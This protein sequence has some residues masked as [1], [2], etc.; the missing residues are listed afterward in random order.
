MCASNNRRLQFPDIGVS[1]ELQAIFLDISSR[2]NSFQTVQADIDDNKKRWLV[3]GICL[4][5]IVS[6]SL[7]KYVA[8]MMKKL[9]VELKMSKKIHKQS[10]SNYLKKYPVTN[11]FYLNYE[12][13]NNNHQQGQN[14]C[15]Y[16]YQVKNF[17]DL[18]KLFLQARMACYT[19]FDDTCD[20]SA[21]LGIIIRVDIFPQLIRNNAKYVRTDVRNPW[22]HCDFSVWD[23]IR[24][25]SSLQLMEQ[26]IRSLNLPSTDEDIVLGDLLKWKMNGL[27]FFSD[28]TIGLEL[29]SSLRDETRSLAEFVITLSSGEKKEFERVYDEITFVYEE[30]NRAMKRVEKLGNIQCKQE[31]TIE[32]LV[33]KTIIL[34]TSQKLTTDHVMIW[35]NKLDSVRSEISQ[36]LDMQSN[37]K[38]SISNVEESQKK[39]QEEIGIITEQLN[40]LSLYR[41]NSRPEKVFFQPPDRIQSFIGR[42][43]EL[44]KLHVCY[45][46]HCNIFHIQ[47]ITGLGGSGKTTLAIEFAWLFQESYPGGVFWL[48][49]ENDIALENSLRNMAIDAQTVGKD[50]KDTTRLTLNWVASIKEQWMLVVDNVDEE[51][52]SLEVRNLLLGAW[53]RSSCGH[54]LFTTRMEPKYLFELIH[55][56]ESD[57][58]DLTALSVDESVHFMAKWTGK[59]ISDEMEE[60]VME[61]GGLPLALEQAAIHINV[62]QCEFKEYLNKFKKSRLKLL[63]KTVSTTVNTMSKDRLSV[64]TTW[65]MNFDYISKE[66]EVENY[67]KAVPWIMEIAAFLYPDYIPQELINMGDPPVEHEELR[68]VL[69]DPIDIK[70]ILSILTRFSLFQRHGKGVVHVHRVVQEVIRE[71]ITEINHKMNVLQSATRMLNRAFKTTRC[72]DDILKVDTSELKN[73]GSLHLWNKLAENACELQKHLFFFIKHNKKVKELCLNPEII[74]LLHEI[75]IFHSVHQRQNEALSA[76]DQMLIVATASNV[77]KEDISKITTIKVPL[78]EKERLR[79]QNCMAPVHTSGE[80]G[81]NL[82][83]SDELRIL[84]NAAF[85]DGKFQKAIQ[86]YTEG[87][88]SSIDSKVDCRL[89][90][91]RSLCYNHLGDHE[92]AL[93]DADHCIEVDP[94]HW[95]GHCRRACAIVN[96]VRLNKLPQGMDPAGMASASIASHLNPQCY[97]GLCMNYYPNLT[98]KVIRAPSEFDSE[99]NTWDSSLKTLLLKAGKYEFGN[100]FV[101]KSVQL[102]GLDKNVTISVKKG[103]DLVQFP[104]NTI[105]DKFIKNIFIH[106]ENV[107]FTFE[108]ETVCATGGFEMSF[109]RCH[110][111]NGKLGCEHFPYCKGGRGCVNSDPTLCK[112]KSEKSTFQGMFNSRSL[113]IQCSGIS[114]YP[115]INALNGGSIFLDKCVLDRCGGGGVLCDGERSYLKITNSIIKNM[116]QSGVEVRNGGILYALNNDIVDNQLHGVLIGP[117]GRGHILGNNV[118]GNKC[119]G[120]L[121]TGESI[122]TIKNNLICHSGKCGISCDGG[123]YEIISNKIFDNWFWGIMAKSRSS[124]TVVDNDIFDNKCG[125]IRIGVNYS[126]VVFI[127]GN[128]IHDHPGPAVYTMAVPDF[129][130]KFQDI[131]SSSDVIFNKLGIPH[132]EIKM[133]TNPPIQ[134]NR[135]NFLNNTSESRHPVEAVEVFAACSF[136]H[137]SIGNLKLCGKCRKAR[138]CSKEC[139]SSH[140]DHH[141]HMCALLRGS[142]SVPI[143]MSET[144]Q[145][146]K[147]IRTFDSSLKGIMEG[148]P[149]DPKSSKRFIVKIQSGEE[150]YPYYPKSLLSLYDQST[151]LDVQFS[152]SGIYHLIMECGVLGANKLSSKKIF[153]WASFEENGSVLRIYTD[154]LPPFQ[155]W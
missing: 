35:D 91:N 33:E 128:T 112:Q 150:Y 108:D 29:L 80:F 151:N 142:F 22:A 41:D 62:I 40:S 141:K 60:L 6:P 54:I 97:H 86:F 73:R 129:L 83:T 4:H 133:F 39:L 136:C 31:N 125:G 113:G 59:A 50:S 106:F 119:E 92:K 77:T 47:A 115:G 16:D 44:L 78:F 51:D 8:P 15:S 134:T 53:K 153:C 96:L 154:N 38:I 82:L 63:K 105:T 76:Q 36:L 30:I 120:I 147:C 137:T 57:C 126:A 32:Q 9:Y 74:R 5:S 25:Q 46:E 155:K 101:M 100:L 10:Y 69:E 72:P 43:Q 42:E 90:L 131:C 121:C 19:G 95:K 65:Q 145:H 103:L 58:T 66:S 110:M 81:E 144:T 85:N 52:L 87:I 79:I 45:N 124:C 123:S 111:S 11:S 56:P 107:N 70:D 149:P 118:K 138:Y 152:N 139:Q 67:G 93:E 37:V 116:R 55:I 94:N 64:R 26:L 68:K 7:R 109:Y 130:C 104:D 127:D 75:S 34:E 88:C 89:Y 14:Y 13:I 23:M 148:P 1:T 114:G 21:L 135:N 27:K 102:V 146:E 84:G 117:N 17:I 140:W 28:S 49:A 48:S 12:T 71:S 24:F 20:M 2:S 61:L 98:F 99:I 3:V 122:G 132:G 18:S 143:R